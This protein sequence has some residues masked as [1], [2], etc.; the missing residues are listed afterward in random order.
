MERSL[1]WALTFGALMNS[2]ADFRMG[3]R[4]AEARVHGG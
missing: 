1:P 3:E 4:D 2:M